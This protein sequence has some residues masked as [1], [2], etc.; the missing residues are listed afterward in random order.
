MITYGRGP[1]RCKEPK[2]PRPH[3][4][5]LVPAILLLLLATAAC[6]AA[7]P[8]ADD[9]PTQTPDTSLVTYW[10]QHPDKK[11]TTLNGATV[12]LDEE[13]TGSH[14]FTLPDT[15]GYN[16]LTVG[17]S[18]GDAY[19]G[20]HWIAGFGDQHSVSGAQVGS[21]CGGLGANIGTYQTAQ[22]GASTRLYVMVDDDTRYSVGVWGETAQTT[23]SA[24]SPT[25]MPPAQ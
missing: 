23:S 14:T 15:A 2:M 10:D 4:A 16:A 11:P 9:A 20:Q 6:T 25:S 12:L 22:Y 18:C 21:D 5:T 3:A 17:V 19:E 24:P 7:T 13:H 8:D 1:I